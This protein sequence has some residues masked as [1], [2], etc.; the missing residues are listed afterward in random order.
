MLS[1]PSKAI[2]EGN[3]L[4]FNFLSTLP[5]GVMLSSA[6]ATCAVESGIDASSSSLIT[7]AVVTSPIV[8]VPT[9][10]GQGVSGVIYKITVLA[11]GSDSKLYSLSGILAVL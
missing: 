11:T 3:F 4:P 2:A 1:F 5:A 7:T 9:V 8:K 10:A 6:I